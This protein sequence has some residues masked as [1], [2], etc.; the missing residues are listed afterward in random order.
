MWSVELLSPKLIR[1]GHSKAPQAHSRTEITE[2]NNPRSLYNT[3]LYLLSYVYNNVRT[4]KKL[5]RLSKY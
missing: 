4:S 5:T 1:K 2:E 3:R